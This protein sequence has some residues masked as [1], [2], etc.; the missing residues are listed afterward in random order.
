MIRPKLGETGKGLGPLAE[1]TGRSC[2]GFATMEGV[3]VFR[4]GRQRWRS[5]GSANCLGQAW[6]WSNR[7]GPVSVRPQTVKDRKRRRRRGCS[8]RLREQGAITAGFVKF[9]GGPKEKRALNPLTAFTEALE[10]SPVQFGSPRTVP[11]TDKNV[12][13]V[14][15]TDVRASFARNYG[16]KGG[17]AKSADAQRQASTR[18]LKVALAEGI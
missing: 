10:E 6:R 18:A 3:R 11:G 15:V 12:R 5:F 4:R 17:L 16:S 9:A 7:D 14:R 1:E 13:V 8:S 2:S